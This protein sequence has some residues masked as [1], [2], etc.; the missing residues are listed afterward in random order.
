MSEPGVHTLRGEELEKKVTVYAE[1][2]NIDELPDH[3]ED[4][5]DTEVAV[6]ELSEEHKRRV[7][8]KLDWILVPQL[9]ILYLLAFLDRSNSTSIPDDPEST[10]DNQQLEML[11]CTS[12]PKLSTST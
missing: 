3:I 8:R 4:L 7:M 6:V 9:T 12:S 5:A 10:A 11:K 2:R 1:G